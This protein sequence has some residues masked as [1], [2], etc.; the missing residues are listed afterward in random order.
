MRRWRNT[1]RVTVICLAPLV[2]LGGPPQMVRAQ[3]FDAQP[4]TFETPAAKPK[5]PPAGRA[6]AKDATDVP[7]QAVKRPVRRRGAAAG[8]RPA[9]SVPAAAPV[10]TAPTPAEQRQLILS[11]VRDWA[12]QLR[13][14]DFP[15]IAQ[16]PFDLVVID[17]A[18]ASGRRFQREFGKEQVRQ[19]Q[20]RSD[21][22]RRLVLA[23]L[24]IGEAERYRF[25]WNQDWYSAEK[26]PA[27]LGPMNSVWD[28]NYIV[29]FWDPEWQKLIFGSPESYLSRIKAQGFDGIYV[30]RA[31]VYQEWAKENPNAEK[32]MVAFLVSLGQ[33]AHADD[34]YFLVVMQN[35]EELVAHKP[36]I[37]AIDAIAK[38]DLLY[39]IDHRG[40]VNDT[41][42]IDW[43]MQK[44]REAG[45]SGRKVM[46]VEYLN[47]PEKAAGA[48]RRIEK[49]GFIVHFTTRDLGDL[50]VVPPDRRS[51]PD[52]V[53]TPPGVPLQR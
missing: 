49:E 1:F 20:Q 47:D 19:A 27:W 43:S 51:G 18:L 48:R 7:P 22:R 21:G 6:I 10:V 24:S 5:R 44:L 35:A 4:S 38:E 53:T 16:S 42:N 9:R 36:V 26:R 46:V 39:G 41:A 15:A 12:F 8:R 29:R 25:Y 17:H 28:G 45:K 23:Y 40:G 50:T 30:D 11:P 2:V 13:R 52:A 14:I 37:D 32:D 3:V 33:A 34:P 31:D